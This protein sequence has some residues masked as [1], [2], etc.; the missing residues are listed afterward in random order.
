MDE[1]FGNLV[2]KTQ[3]HQAVKISDAIA[4]QEKVSSYA[5]KD[6]KAALQ[7]SA[8]TDEIITRLGG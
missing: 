2:F 8:L 5:K 6:S 7:I 4:L 3:V 1:E